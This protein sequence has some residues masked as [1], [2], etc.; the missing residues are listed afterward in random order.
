MPQFSGLPGLAA[1]SR[2]SPGPTTAPLPLQ[3]AAL[4]ARTRRV[5]CATALRGRR[6]SGSG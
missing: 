5:L 1:T 2:R 6:P 4:T 3:G